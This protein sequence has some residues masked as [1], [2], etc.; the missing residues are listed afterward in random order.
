LSKG[1]KPFDFEIMVE[2]PVQERLA[3]NYAHS[4]ARIGIDARVRLV[5]EVQYQRR[6]QNFDFDMMIGSW[7]AS[8]S[9]GSEERTRWG[10][11]AA[12][13]PASYNLAG[14]KSPAADAM[15]EALLAAKSRDDF[16]T[17]AR[18]LDRVLLSG[19]YIVPLYHSPEQWIAA[20]AALEKPAQL[21]AYMSPTVDPTLEAW[22]RKK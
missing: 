20:S 11:Q 19:F 10:S 21:P 18:A 3:L 14:V 17:S 5:D 8:A 9:P 7:V 2:D 12:D 16:V 1:G 15:I 13:E 22:W 4:L 6:R